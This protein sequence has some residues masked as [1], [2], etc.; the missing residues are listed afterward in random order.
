MFFECNLSAEAPMHLHVSLR[1]AYEKTAA[2]VIGRSDRLERALNISGLKPETFQ[3][4][5]AEL[6]KTEEKREGNVEHFDRMAPEELAAYAKAVYCGKDAGDRLE[7]PNAVVLFDTAF[8]SV[9]EWELLRHIGIGGSDAAVIQGASP[10]RT[11]QEL[12]HDKIG[13][14][15]KIETGDDRTSVFKRGHILEDEVIAAFCRLSGAE[16]IRETRMFQSLLYPH[17]IADIDAILR[18]PDGTLAIFEAKST[19]AANTDAWRKGRIPG[20]YVY[21]TR[22]YPAVLSDDR[23]RKVYI[24]CLFTVDLEMGGDYVGS[25]FDLERFISH[26]VERDADAEM[27]LLET[28]EAF[29][30]NHIE[31]GIAPPPSNEFKKD[32]ELLRKYSGPADMNAPAVEIKDTEILHLL[33]RYIV[34]E[35][36]LNNAKAAMKVPEG[37]QEEIKR[38]IIKFLGTCTKGTATLSGNRVLEISYKPRKKTVANLEMLQVRAPDLY[39]E[40]V[41]VNPEGSRPLLIR[42]K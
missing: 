5:T 35:E 22:H 23:I 36:K 32:A 11:V 42:V 6:F 29:W 18:M 26:E 15:V 16:R 30:E 17:S 21:Q 33:E 3:L 9:K 25:Q 27:E 4:L 37:E 1:Q 13:T 34:I 28:N 39:R 31:S 12:Y 14:P 40:I 19:V 10:Y 8:A 2:A 7:W 38:E 20:H 41:T 24:G